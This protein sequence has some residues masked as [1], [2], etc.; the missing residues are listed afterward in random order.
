MGIKLLF[1]KANTIISHVVWIMLSNLPI[2]MRLHKFFE[3]YLDYNL[4]ITSVSDYNF[5]WSSKKKKDK[6]TQYRWK[7]MIKTNQVK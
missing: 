6:K 1:T 7:E 2:E 3:V 5:A 4:Q